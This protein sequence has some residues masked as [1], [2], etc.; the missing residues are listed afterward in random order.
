MRISS[1]R[2]AI[3]GRDGPPDAGRVVW[4]D[5]A[6]VGQEPARVV[7]E[8]DAV[9]QQAPPLPGMVCDDPDRAATWR[10]SIRAPLG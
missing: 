8:D 10:Q 1:T 7:E 4:R 5:G 9:A 3:S 6:A 2:L